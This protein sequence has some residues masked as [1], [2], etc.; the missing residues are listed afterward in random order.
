LIFHD[1]D[2]SDQEFGFLRQLNHIQAPSFGKY[3]FPGMTEGVNMILQ[4]T[5]AK[6]PKNKSF[7]ERHQETL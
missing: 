3:I 5:L 7:A 1:I 4:N 2:P 6:I